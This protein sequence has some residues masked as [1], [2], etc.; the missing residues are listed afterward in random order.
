M[1]K[2]QI[3]TGQYSSAGRK[4]INQDFHGIYIPKEPALSTKGIAIAIADGISSSQVSQIASQT[5][6]TSFFEDY[7]CTPESWGVKQ[8]AQR[9]INAI[10]SWLLAQT[11]QSPYRF[12]KNKGYVCTFSTLILKAD[13]A[14]IFHSGDSRIYRLTNDSPEAAVSLE[15]LTIDHRQPA[16]EGG[17]YLSRALGI[18]PQLDID[19]QSHTLRE[20]E[21]FLLTTDGIHEFVNAELVINHIRDN[22]IN[23]DLAAQKIGQAALDNGSDDNLTIQIV[24]I[25]KLPEH[26]LESIYEQAV[27]LPLPPALKPRMLFDGY[28]IIRDIYISSRS[29][30]YLARDTD[31]E[32][33]VALKTPSTE[34]QNDKNYIERFLM[35]EWVANRIDNAHV[36]KSYRATRKRNYMYTVTE[37]IEG[38][39]LAQWM[40]DNPQP[41]LDAVRNIVSQ[42]GKGLQAFHRQEMLHQ[43]LR[44]NNV[45]IDPSGTVKIIDFGSTRVAGID[46]I[47]SSNA[48]T[49]ILG[50]VQYSAPEYFL[51]EAGS[52]RSDL[53]SLAVITYHMLSGRLPYGI[54]IARSTTRTQQLKLT[55][56]S[57]L[58]DDQAIPVWIDETLKKALQINPQKRY[59]EVAEFV[60]ELHIPNK[61]FLNKSRPPLIERNPVAF[62]QAVSAILL[63]IVIWQAA[64]LAAV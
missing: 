25:N 4:E 53:F 5:A 54:N 51:G 37:F 56:A 34:L 15:Q 48:E 59:W 7:F 30:V 46:E 38:Q 8:S 22:S 40:Q 52:P 13:K 1:K 42:I 23:L 39:T 6:V 17:D 9:V 64:T 12:D 47:L 28:E 41:T 44:P 20:G 57:V 21:I 36:L 45:M 49:A 60:H 11:Q 27:N 33:L 63:A 31:T 61:E 14:H 10:N 24:R 43:D 2:L 32:Q 58:N 35:E 16:A 19:Y 18:H 62:W 55:Y 29:H 3:S 26:S 50:T